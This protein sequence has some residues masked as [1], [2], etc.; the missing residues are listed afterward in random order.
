M[1]SLDVYRRELSEWVSSTFEDGLTPEEDREVI[2]QTKPRR[3]LQRIA[4]TSR[5]I[6]KAIELSGFTPEVM[7]QVGVGTILEAQLFRRWYPEVRIIGF[8][9]LLPGRYSSREQN[10][11]DYPGLLIPMPIYSHNGTVPFQVKG[12]YLRSFVDQSGSHNV[13]LPC[14]KLD[15]ALLFHKHMAGPMLLWMDCEGSELHAL[16]GGKLALALCKW[17]L[18]EIWE[19][20]ETTKRF[21]K[22]AGF[23]L[24]HKEHNDYIWIR[25]A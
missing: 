9:P 11:K 8:D 15:D 4:R 24:I 1:V 20:V 19:D 16:R 21:L 6:K 22:G 23:E 17:I 18:I 10:A 12:R 5:R 3:T 13:T 25:H 14:E 7:C 2:S